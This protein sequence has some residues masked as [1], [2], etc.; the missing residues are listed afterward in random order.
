MKRLIILLLV[1]F[2][3]TGVA[4]AETADFEN[5]TLDSNSYWNGSDEWDGSDTSSEFKSGN[6][7]FNNIYGVDEDWGFPFWYGFAYSNHTDTEISGQ[8]SQ[9]NAITGS[10][11][12]GS[13]TY[14][15]AYYSTPYGDVVPEL[16]TISLDTEQVVTGMY[17]TNI[18]WA[19]YTMSVGDEVFGIDPFF[20]TDDSTDYFKVIITG[21]DQNGDP[22]NEIEKFLA[23]DGNIVKTWEWVDLRSLGTIKSIKFSMDS[24]DKSSGYINTPTYFAID[25]FNGTGPGSDDGGSDSSTCFIKAAGASFF[26]RTA[27]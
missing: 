8:A 17:I 21:F 27:R 9:Y 14:A 10:G 3:T 4:S 22:L 24:S 15:V 2:V 19:Y 12:N 25:N 7:S 20:T 6:A 11:V 18:N 13:E 26:S 1:L 5:L 16:P 23:K